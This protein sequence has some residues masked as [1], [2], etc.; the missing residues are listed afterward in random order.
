MTSK[1]LALAAAL[2][3]ALAAGCGASST[4]EPAAPG[5]NAA[6]ETPARPAPGSARTTL[7]I[8]SVSDDPE[9]EAAVF[10][11]FVDHV[12]GKLRGAGV[13]RGEVVVTGTVEAMAER[14]RKGEV[15]LY[16]D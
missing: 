7:V 12:A 13:T 10:Q 14:L 3:A 1:P 4:V 15:D 16:I 8:G 2:L 5:A 11:P 9:E 6:A